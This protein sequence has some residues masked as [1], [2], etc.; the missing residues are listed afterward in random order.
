MRDHELYNVRKWG[1]RDRV[2]VRVV[3]AVERVCA[4]VSAGQRAREGVEVVGGASLAR[5]PTV[6][7]RRPST[8]TGESSNGLVCETIAARV[9]KRARFSDSEVCQ[10]QERSGGSNGLVG[11]TIAARVKKRTRHSEAGRVQKRRLEG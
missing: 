1:R 2:G 8:V 4:T 10:V 9:K 7:G 3:A 5:P 11:E 6:A